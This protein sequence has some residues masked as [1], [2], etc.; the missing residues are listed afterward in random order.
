LGAVYLDVGQV[1]Q[2]IQ[3]LEQA[4][5]IAREIGDRRYE[6]FWLGRLARAYRDLGQH[7]RAIELL[8][9]DL[10]NARDIGDRQAEG[11]ILGNLG[12]ACY[13]IGQ[14][15]QAIEFYGQ[16]VAIAREI[17]ARGY[18]G[19]WLGHLGEAYRAVGQV[20]RAL[21]LYEDALTI[22]RGAGTRRRESRHLVGL[23]KTFLAAGRTAE[24][25]DYCSEALALD[26]QVTRYSAALTLGMVFLSQRNPAAVES[27]TDAAVYSRAMLDRTVGLYEPRYRLAA[28]LVG[29]AVCDPRWN[30]ESERVELLAPALA[31]YRRALEITSAPGVVQDAIR[32]LE[33][34]R[35]AGIEGLEPVF[36]LLE[37]ALV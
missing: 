1:G 19:N 23:G 9:Q 18:E 36:E 29:Q 22:I 7:K 26:V 4:L 20:E 31:E 32:D 2:A 15:A 33:M 10:S 37:S 21:K 8:K 27:F 16:A 28:A 5:T 30:Q 6:G 17:G 3:L 35:A 34:I 13:A 24:A 14:V 11:A 25:R 12:I